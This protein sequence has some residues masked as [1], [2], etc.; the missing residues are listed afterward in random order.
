M[1]R[2]YRCTLQGGLLTLEVIS[3]ACAFG[4]RTRD[5]T[6]K[7]WQRLG[8]APEPVPPGTPSPRPTATSA[9]YLSQ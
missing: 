5:L 9:E 2:Y 7:T 3:D 1:W 8:D 6:E 4:E